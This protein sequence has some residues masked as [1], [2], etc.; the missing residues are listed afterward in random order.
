MSFTENASERK[1]FAAVVQHFAIHRE[2]LGIE[3]TIIDVDVVV[4][5]DGVID[6]LKPVRELR[7]PVYKCDV[8]VM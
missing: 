2:T 4:L 1:D 3:P 6:C 7:Q 8:H 5:S